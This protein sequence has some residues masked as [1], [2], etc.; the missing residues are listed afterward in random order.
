MRISVLALDDCFD[1]GLA[2]VLDTLATANE[3]AG[4]TLFDVS[5]VGVR[6]RVTTSNGFTVPLV[7]GSRP[8]LAIVP[9]LGC[10]T[11]ERLSAALERPDIADACARIRSWSKSGVRI[12]AACT[13]TFVL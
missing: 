5:V 10:K 3:L 13:A 7:A 6:K 4:K 11:P 9:A 8:D 12:A 2:I 1:S